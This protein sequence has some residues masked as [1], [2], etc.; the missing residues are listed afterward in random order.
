MNLKKRLIIS[1][2]LTVLI[3]IIITTLTA[4]T[5]IFMY[6]KVV[7]KDLSY[8]SFKNL[9]LLKSELFDASNSLVK[10]NPEIIEKEDYKQ[11][12][13]QR[14]AAVNGKIIIVKNNEVIFSSEGISKIEAEKSMDELRTT[15]FNNTVKIN[16]ISYII[17]ASPLNFKDK[18]PGTAILLVPLEKEEAII[19]NFIITILMV[20]ILS[21]IIV[22]II[23]SSRFSDKILR[24]ISLLKNAAS[25]ISNGNLQCE[26]IEDGDEEIQELCHDFEVMRIQLKDSIRMR[27]KYDDNRK[28][29][30]SSISH[31]LRTP[32]TSIKGYVEGILDGVANSPEKMERY[33]KTIYSKAEQV[34]SMID[35]LLLYSK[36]DLNQIPF[37]FEKTDIT[38]YFKDCIYESAPELE[39]SNIKIHLE[40]HLNQAKYIMIDRERM[41]R[42][43]MNIID[44]SRKYMDKERGEITIILRD[45]IS[46]V[47]I[48]LR[49]NGTG[50]NKDHIDKIFDRFYRSDSARSEVKGSGLGLAIAKQIVE[51]HKGR[52][53]A[54]SHEKVGTSIIISLAK[55]QKV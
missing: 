40:N 24:P 15:S 20:F 1:N 43:V 41:R 44:N 19:E 23:V 42:V 27:M 10:Q 30:V 35:D 33:L 16:N 50:I 39:K 25:E 55:M 11:Y 29:L 12:L 21:F 13:A 28:M 34:D 26:I 8:N 53:W 18:T 3:P 47:I 52:I 5:F 31:D 49:D 46:S 4:F 22:N 51:G 48:E 14:L 54:V 9:M 7:N 6:T 17:E 2:A 36:L 45:T 37:N 32:I 38:D